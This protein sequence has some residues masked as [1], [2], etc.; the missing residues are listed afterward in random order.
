MKFV[1]H[2]AESPFLEI[3]SLD[4]SQEHFQAATVAIDRRQS[5]QKENLIDYA[6][7]YSLAENTNPFKLI[8]LQTG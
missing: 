3:K 2:D 4:T 6:I 5:K 1:F 8:N 7:L